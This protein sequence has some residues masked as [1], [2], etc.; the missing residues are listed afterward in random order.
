MVI[1][2][3][4]NLN[5]GVN[6]IRVTRLDYLNTQCAIICKLIEGRDLYEDEWK[7]IFI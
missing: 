4:L 6:T 3:R 5:S 7:Y 2:Y 1:I